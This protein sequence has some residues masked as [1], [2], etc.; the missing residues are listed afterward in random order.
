LEGVDILISESLGEAGIAVPVRT[1]D[2]FTYKKYACSKI[3]VLCMVKRVE[4]L[5]ANGVLHCHKMARI[6]LPQKRYSYLFPQKDTYGQKWA[7]KFLLITHAKKGNHTLANKWHVCI[8][9]YNNFDLFGK[10][11]PPRPEMDAT[12]TIRDI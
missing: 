2:L 11:E 8:A 7:R 6:S 1:V 9:G 5:C 10:M 3:L 4:N 12:G